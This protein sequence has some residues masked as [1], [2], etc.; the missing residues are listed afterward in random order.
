MRVRVRSS[1]LV[2]CEGCFDLSQRKPAKAQQF[3]TFCAL[4][5]S[6]TQSSLTIQLNSTRNHLQPVEIAKK[7]FLLEIVWQSSQLT[8]EYHPR[9]GP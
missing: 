6:S 9:V 5:V 8:L 3:A 2:F 4:G 7:R 1:E